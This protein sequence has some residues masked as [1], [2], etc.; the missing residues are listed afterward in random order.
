MQL[1]RETREFKVPA[2]ELLEFQKTKD[3][4]DALLDSMPGWYILEYILD[5]ETMETT[6]KVAKKH[7]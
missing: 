2:G 6:V 4:L 5:D 3:M 7:D 1:T